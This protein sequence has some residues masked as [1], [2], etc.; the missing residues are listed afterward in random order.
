MKNM[1]SLVA[2]I[3]ILLASGYAYEEGTRGRAVAKGD[4][5]ITNEDL[6]A[7][8][9]DQGSS[10]FNQMKTPEEKNVEGSGAGGTGSGSESWKKESEQGKEPADKKLMEPGNKEPGTGGYDKDI[11]TTPYTPSY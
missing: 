8:T 1:L 9:P 5:V 2:G 6:P 7:T 3:V 10:T 4:T 11:D